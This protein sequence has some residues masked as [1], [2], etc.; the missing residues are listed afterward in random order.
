MVVTWHAAAQVEL[1]GLASA[2]RSGAQLQL[3]RVARLARDLVALQDESDALTVAA[4]SSPPGD[5]VITNLVNVSIVA[6][7]M[8]VRLGF[9]GEE[10]ERLALAGLLHDVGLWVVPQSLV[11]KA[12]GLT[13]EERLILEQHPVLGSAL[14]RDAGSDYGW[15]ADVVLQAHERINGSGYPN[16]RRGKEVE[17]LA[18]LIGVADIFDALI[19]ERPY[20]RRLFP[21]EA[22]KELLVSERQAFP[23]NVIAL[24]VEQLSFYPLGTR[25]KLTTGDVGVVVGVNSAYP[26]RP[27]VQRISAGDGGSGRLDLSTVPGLAIVEALEP[28]SVDAGQ[29]FMSAASSGNMPIHTYGSPDDQVASLLE[30]LDDLAVMMQG[31]I[32]VQEASPDQVVVTHPILSPEEPGLRAAPYVG[33]A[34]IH[35][36]TARW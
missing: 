27:V 18:Q 13:R 2:V 31:V 32:E 26:L 28:P 1:A 16:G 24:L 22:M 5:P 3:T 11:R 4:L 25:V 33:H 7:A 17:E 15:L 6:T 30:H 21:H 36:V 8:G 29:W 14:V 23:P 10:L 35:G 9:C 12:G 19:S 20:R 34:S